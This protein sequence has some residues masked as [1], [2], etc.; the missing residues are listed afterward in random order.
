MKYM[1]QQKLISWMWICAGDNDNH[2]DHFG[3]E[4]KW[5]VYLWAL[6]NQPS[7]PCN[8]VLSNRA[9]STSELASRSSHRSTFP[10]WPLVGEFS[11][12]CSIYH[13]HITG[14]VIIKH[15]QFTENPNKIQ[16][17]RFNSMVCF[18]YLMTVV[19]LM[20]VPKVEMSLKLIFWLNCFKTAK[21]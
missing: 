7:S 11:D 9:G 6:R 1:S 3:S 4:Y 13:V 20:P 12:H 8:H 19:L 21:L 10:K 17:Y 2:L 18:C 15:K 16:T 5:D 14:S